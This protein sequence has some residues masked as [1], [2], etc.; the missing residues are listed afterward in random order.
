Y[1]HCQRSTQTAACFANALEFHW[2]VK[3]RFGQEVGTRAA[4]LPGFELQ[5]ITHA[6]RIIFKNFTRRG[7]EWQFPQSRILHATGEAHQLGA[8]VFTLRNVLVPLNAVSEDS[9]DVTQRYN[10]VDAGRFAPCA[11]SRRERRLGTW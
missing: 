10:V 5:A 8:R 9:R 4:W 11:R 7:A 6:A 3:V 1:R 2:Q